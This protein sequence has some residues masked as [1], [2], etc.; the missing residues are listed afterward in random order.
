MAAATTSVDGYLTSTDWNTF[1]NKQPAGTYVNSVSATSPI[2]S[3]GGVTPTIAMPAATTSVNGYLTSTDWNTF[4]NKTSN[5]GTVTSVGGTGT[6]NGIT[7]TGTVTTSGNLTLGGT[8][9]GVS[10]TTQVSGTLPVANG[11]TGTAT[12]FTAGSVVFA[13]ASGVYSQD[14]A[15]LFFDNTNDRLGI[16]TSSPS[17]KLT[18]GGN[19]PSAGALAAVGAAAGISLALSDNI[20][21]SLYVRHPAAGPVIGTDGGNALRFAT[22]GNAA[23]DEKMRISAAGNVGIGTAS[24]AQKLHVVGAIIGQSND[25]YFGDYSSGAYVDIG[26]LGTSD[27]WLD[28]RSGTLTNVPLQFRTKGTG[29]F[30]WTQGAS[31]RMRLDSSGNLLVGTMTVNGRISSVPK[32][33]FAPGITAGTWSSSAGMSSSGS[34]GGGF[35]WIDGAGGYCAWAENGGADFNIAGGLTGNVVANG[36]FLNGFSAT[37]WSSRSDERLKQNL[38]PITNALNKTCSL[39]AVTGA[40]KNFP[41]EQ[42][43]FLLAQDVQKVLPEAVCVADKRSSE[44]YL[45][46]AYTQVIPLLVAAIQELKAEIDLLKGN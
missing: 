2:T 19:P 35:S 26:N 9:S 34:F 22:N 5:T 20:N 28:T 32:A 1:N 6:V 17:S 30:V 41:D 3:S 21:C 27:V 23:S 4:N 37:S 12:A 38:Q 33:G 10:L 31:E 36:V 44:Q 40:Y 18:V 8:L 43:A 24:P 16:G 46:L 25:N 45:G 42:Q 15:A 14:N 7:L 11:G 13:G 39:R 29:A